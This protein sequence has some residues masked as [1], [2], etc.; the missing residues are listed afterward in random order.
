[1]N[2]DLQTNRMFT[3]DLNPLESIDGCSE[4]QGQAGVGEGAYLG[5]RASS[6]L[7][8]STYGIRKVLVNAAINNISCRVVIEPLM[9]SLSPHVSKRTSYQI[10][11]IAKSCLCIVVLV[12][13]INFFSIIQSVIVGPTRGYDFLGLDVSAS[14]FTN[15]TGTIAKVIDGDTVDISTTSDDAATERIRLV[16]VDAPEYLQPGYLE[17]KNFVTE[18]C[19]GKNAQVD[20]DDKQDRSYGRIV[21]VLYCNGTNVNADILDNDLASI[22]ES[23]CAGSEFGNSDWAKRNGC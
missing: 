17:A 8:D 9:V 15:F 11:Q 13:S 23:F 21:A 6:V 5:Y 2:M 7:P 4:F 12:M 20:P 16:L 1:M 3:V 10:G 14:Q 18:I 19:Q 22:Y